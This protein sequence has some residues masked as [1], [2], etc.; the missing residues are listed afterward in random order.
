MKIELGDKTRNLETQINSRT[1]VRTMRFRRT[2]AIACVAFFCCG[3]LRATEEIHLGIIGADSSHAVEFTRLL[4]DPGSIDHVDGARVVAAYRGGN[5]RMPLSRD[6]IE[7]FTRELTSRWKVPFVAHISDLCPRVD[8]LLLLS[9]DPRM[10]EREF[11]E[12]LQCGKPIF[13]DKP[14]APTLQAARAMARSADQHKVAWF[15]SSSMRFGAVQQLR[16]SD[17]RGADVW[18]PGALGEGYALD[19][20]W[21][22]IHSIEMLYSVLGPG[23]RTVSRVHSPEGDV[24]TGVWADGRIGTVHVV[25]PDM[26]FGIA[27]FHA[28]G[29]AEV[30]NPLPI[31]YAPLLHAVV[32]FMR[33]R[34]PPVAERETLEIFEFMDAAQRSMKDGGKTVPIAQTN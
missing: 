18:G 9:V 14:F 32:D 12:A 21:Y 20:S 15:S 11:A 8:G 26:S 29:R 25:R 4:N 23:V 13:V 3:S 7:A 22:A 30:L 2:L 19:L 6:R 33:S 34:Q 24:L 28:G 10:R 27:V 31:D 17:L 16:A 1:W 5:P